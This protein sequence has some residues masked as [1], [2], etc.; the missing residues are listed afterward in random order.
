MKICLVHNAY[1][2]LSGEEVAVEGL[3]DSLASHGH[4][5][6]PF[7]RSSAELD[8]RELRKIGAFFTGI[9]NIAAR[10]EFARMLDSERPDLVHINNLFPIISPSILDETKRHGIPTVMTVHNYRLLCPTGLLFSH[11][12]VCHRCLDGGEWWCA[13]RNCTGEWPKS[14][15]YA[16]R[17]WV[18]RLRRSFVDGI[19]RFIALTEF[20][21]LMLLRHGYPAERIDVV[22]N[23]LRLET[24]ESHPTDGEYVGYV[25]RISPEK[26]VD[27]IVD[28]AK[29]QPDIRF[30]FAGH[31]LRMPRLLR[32]APGNC[33]FVG[34]VPR[35]DLAAF[36][37]G[38]RFTVFASKWY[39]V[40]PLSMVETM[41]RGKAVICSR[42]GSLP[43]LVE[44]G[45]TGLLFE[46]GN[47]E[48][49]GR[50]IEYLWNRPDLCHKMGAAARTKVLAMFSPD[51][52]YAQL[53]RTYETACKGLR[54]NS[55]SANLVF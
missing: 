21:K 35:R 37:A 42:I 26:G 30:R 33:E 12:E 7:F 48:D 53:L 41:A 43:E 55:H 1:G 47:V 32:Q 25:G 44:E 40:S 15:G 20:A 9:Y 50:N 54:V 6:I 46:P 8:G 28:A 18:A 34:E 52:T 51:A 29:H 17:N 22:R 31:C 11:G 45:V 16:V 24:T 19:D 36:V 14:A 3:R 5:V 49:L 38:A 10:R 39:E 23:I 27:T 13:I 2:K 4:T